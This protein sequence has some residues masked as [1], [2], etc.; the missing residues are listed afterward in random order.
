MPNV[1]AEGSLGPEEVYTSTGFVFY[2]SSYEEFQKFH[3]LCQKGIDDNSLMSKQD[4]RMEI[5]ESFKRNVPNFHQWL[6][7]VESKGYLYERRLDFIKDIFK[8]IKTGK[9][10]VSVLNWRTLLMDMDNYEVGPKTGRDLN[11]LVGTGSKTPLTTAELISQWCS[12]EGGFVDMV[13]TLSI[14]TEIDDVVDNSPKNSSAFS[15]NI[16]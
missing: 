5:V 3:L 16:K 14:L 8:F 7:K 10:T 6:V 1:V 12:V 9:R 2:S 4:Y 11:D 13:W 15:F